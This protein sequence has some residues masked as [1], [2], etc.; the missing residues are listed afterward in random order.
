MFPLPVVRIKSF[1]S[2]RY[3]LKNYDL[4]DKVPDYVKDMILKSTNRFHL[5]NYSFCRS[6][7]KEGRVLSFADKKVSLKQIKNVSSASALVTGK[8]K[9][10]K[11]DNK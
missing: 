3:E 2:N 10:I 5:F 4:L 11:S 9:S 7:Y 8:N 6:K 1:K